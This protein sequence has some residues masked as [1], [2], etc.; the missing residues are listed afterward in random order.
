LQLLPREAANLRRW[1]PQLGQ[2]GFDMEPFGG[3]SFIVSAVPA[4]LSDCPPDALIREMLNTAHDA[5]REP[6]WNL[7]ADLVKSAA[8]HKAVRAGQKLKPDE[9]RL[10]LEDL[11]RTAMPSTCPHGRPLWLKLTHADIARL[12]HRT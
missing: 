7:A 2:L 3:D 11:D 12:F 10:L 9:L 4:I 1:I 6:E 5:E 8:C